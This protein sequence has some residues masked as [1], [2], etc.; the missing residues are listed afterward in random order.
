MILK[1]TLKAL[2]LAATLALASGGA[3]A[4]IIGAGVQNSEQAEDATELILVVWSES[5]KR[6]YVQDLGV[7]IADIKANANTAGWNKSFAV[8]ALYASSALPGASDTKWFVAAYD[9]YTFTGNLEPGDLQLVTTVSS[10][11][12][13]SAAQPGLT[14]DQMAAS[15]D[16]WNEFM[17]LTENAGFG[18]ASGIGTHKTAVNGFSLVTDESQAHVPATVND[19]LIN[20]FQYSMANAVGDSSGLYHFTSSDP[21]DG[22]LSTTLTTYASTV[23]FD[24]NTLSISAVPEPGTYAMLV[25]GMLAIGAVVRRRQQPR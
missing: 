13:I 7:S 15:F 2:A 21:F 17:V 5:A 25:A 4:D 19:N 14:G 24:G 11:A 20:N 8:D 1:T 23:T 16:V 9:T 6:S 22:T 18:G 10:S 12:P 3:S